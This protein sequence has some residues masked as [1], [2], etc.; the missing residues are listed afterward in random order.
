MYK[1]T[2][3]LEERP[4]PLKEIGMEFYV[5]VW[6]SGEP[7]DALLDRPHSFGWAVSGHKRALAERLVRAVNAGA[8][9]GTAF[10]KRDVYGKTYIE[11]DC[12]V[13]GRHLNTDLQRLGY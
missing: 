2:A 3:Y 11:A 6:W 10:V 1:P 8:V 13:S 9:F 7:D 4:S 5:S 12:K